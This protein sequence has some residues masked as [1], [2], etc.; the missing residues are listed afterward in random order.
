MSRASNRARGFARLR[1]W[2]RTGGPQHGP[3]LLTVSSS[4][5]SAAPLQEPKLLRPRR[6]A[7]RPEENHRLSRARR[8]PRMPGRTTG[9]DPR[10]RNTRAWRLRQ[11]GQTRRGCSRAPIIRIAAPT[12]LS[13]PAPAV[14]D[15]AP[16]EI[17]R[18]PTPARPS[19][20]LGT[21]R[22]DAR[23]SNRAR[24]LARLSNSRAACGGG[25]V[26]SSARRW[27]SLSGPAPAV[28]DRAPGEIRTPDPQVRSL[29]LY[30]TELRAHRQPR[31]I[32]QGAGAS[33]ARHAL[34][35]RMT[36]TASPA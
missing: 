16:G 22:A 33:A 29:M 23:A 6:T 34:T 31:N 1:G 32:Y 25:R 11:R 19:L 9:C 5:A 14:V 30:P 8:R 3:L 15:C 27:A 24:G 28:V 17:A 20:T 36:A 12:S 21:A 13:G 4:V 26:F 10:V 7:T 35:M 2:S 18:G